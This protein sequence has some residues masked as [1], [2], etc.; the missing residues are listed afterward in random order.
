MVFVKEG[1]DPRKHGK[2]EKP[3]PILETATDWCI[4][5]DLPAIKYQFP[6]LVAVT[7][8]RPDL[9]LSSASRKHIVLVELTVP[10][11]A[12]LCKPSSAR[13]YDTMDQERLRVIV[14]TRAG[15]SM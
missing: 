8:K 14:G 13:C 15:Q 11:N 2:R 3:R 7:D 10:Q 6:S 4:M 9:V 1:D 5:V 12:T